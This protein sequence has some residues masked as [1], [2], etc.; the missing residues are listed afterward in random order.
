MELTRNTR[1]AEVLNPSDMLCMGDAVIRNSGSPLMGVESISTWLGVGS[2]I[3]SEV[4]LWPGDPAIDPAI[5]FLKQRHSA[6]WNVSFCDGHVET[7]RAIDL[8]NY[9]NPFVT[10]RWNTD[11][12]PHNEGWIPPPPPSN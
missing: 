4:M 10:Q 7:L 8:F 3:Y 1:E 2:D 6:R 5:Q 11:H 12:K 9:R